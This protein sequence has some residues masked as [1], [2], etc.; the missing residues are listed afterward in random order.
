MPQFAEPGTS[1][2]LSQK[3]GEKKAFARAEHKV[4]NTAGQEG[5][6]ES[7]QDRGEPIEGAGAGKAMWPRSAVTS[8]S[9]IIL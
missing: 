3:Q 8:W 6:Q 2:K 9:Q 5:F 1:G 7:Q 4:G